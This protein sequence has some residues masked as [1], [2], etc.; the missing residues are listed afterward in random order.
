MEDKR[1]CPI[2]GEPTKGKEL[3]YA[4]WSKKR[5]GKIVQC[6]DCGKWHDSETP[7]ECTKG[8]EK[9]GNCIVCGEETLKESFLFCRNC[10]YEKEEFVETISKD[11]DIREYRNYYYNLKDM[12]L[13]MKDLPVVKRNCNKLVAIA[14][15]AAQIGDESLVQR[16]YKDVPAIIENKKKIPPQTPIIEKERKDNDEKKERLK[17]AQDGHRVL[18]DGE[19]TIDDVLYKNC[20]LHCYGKNIDEILE[21]NKICDWFIPIVNGK[22][23]YIEYWGMTTPEYLKERQEKEKLYKK[24]NIPYIS[25][26]KDDPKGDTQTFSSRLIKQIKKLA[27]EKYTFMPEWK[28]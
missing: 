23:I 20:I 7:C 21:K 6:P 25:I 1:V 28:Q 16:V 5:D 8:E 26:E 24:Y 22:G 3:C 15:I 19:V 12:I 27:I 13:T 2:C 17:V 9:K 18:S 11:K 10:Y 4:C 14:E